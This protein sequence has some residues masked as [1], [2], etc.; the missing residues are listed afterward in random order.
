M[1]GHTFT[2]ATGGTV[3]TYTELIARCCS[4]CAVVYAIPVRKY[5]KGRADKAGWYCPNGHWQVPVGKT[6][7][8][9]LREQL[10]GQFD[11]TARLRAERDQAKASAAAQKG[12]ATKLKKR[13]HAG[14]CPHCNRH[15]KD[16][17]RHCK[18]QH[19]EAPPTKPSER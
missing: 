1:S 8:Q 3:E 2:A 10:N 14:L 16:L 5:E 7:E 18:N 9:K 17:E 4:K 13:V 19:P 12:V 6:P 15:F 11:E